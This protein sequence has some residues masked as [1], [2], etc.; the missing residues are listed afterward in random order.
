MEECLNRYGLTA[1]D[2]SLFADQ[3]YRNIK[4]F[5]MMG[6]LTEKEAQTVLQRIIARTLS[7]VRER[8]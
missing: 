1:G 8:D 7:N 4:F 3:G 6:W 2:M 5:R